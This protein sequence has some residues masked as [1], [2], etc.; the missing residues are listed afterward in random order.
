[1]QKLWR[2][3]R[4]KIQNLI[5]VFPSKAHIHILYLWFHADQIGRGKSWGTIK[6]LTKQFFDEMVFPYYNRDVILLKK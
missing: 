4:H 5:D 1:M 3:R 6:H 2:Y